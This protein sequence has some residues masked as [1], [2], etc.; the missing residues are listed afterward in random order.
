MNRQPDGLKKCSTCMRFLPPYGFYKTKYSKDG[1]QSQCKQ[2][3]LAHQRNKREERAKTRQPYR[4]NKTEVI[5]G[6]LGKTCFTCKAF[7]PTAEFFKES[8]NYSGLSGSCKSCEFE[9]RRVA[10]KKHYE[11]HHEEAL[12]KH[13]DYVKRNYETVATKR[14]ATRLTQAETL[15]PRYVE[16]LLKLPKKQI[17]QHLIDLKTQAVQIHRIRK[18]ISTTLKKGNS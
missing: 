16:K 10:A 18:D 2:C 7:K 1:L 17:T 14:R 5:G 4:T 6:V 15:D 12:E 13:A 11:T 9:R 3:F 8:K